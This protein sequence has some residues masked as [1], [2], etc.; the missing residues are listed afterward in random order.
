MAFV[1]YN[2]HDLEKG[3]GTLGPVNCPQTKLMAIP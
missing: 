1:V 2:N 3:K